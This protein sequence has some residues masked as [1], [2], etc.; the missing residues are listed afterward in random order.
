MIP[1]RCKITNHG[2]RQLELNVIY[3]L[4]G[5]RRH[6]HY[7]IDLYIFNPYQL[8]M[9][10]ER[11]GTNRFLQD[12][13][14]Y[15]RYT[16]ALIAF[17]KLI[18]PMCDISPITRI[19][20]C[21]KVPDMA[22]DIDERSILY[23]LR[24]L[25]NA[26]H[27]Q[28]RETRR[29]LNEMIA[30][31]SPA[32]DILERVTMLLSDN[33]AFLAAFRDLRSLFLD[34]RLSHKLR[35]GFYWTDEAVSLT[36]EKA[37]YRIYRQCLNR[38]DL[39]DVRSMLRPRLGQEQ[40]Y[41]LERGYRTII[42]PGDPAANEYFVY[43]EGELKKWAEACMFM[44]SEPAKT[45]ERFG[46]ILMGLSAGAA[47]TFAV[48]ATVMASRWFADY[49]VPWAILIIVAYMVKD[50]LK[51]ILR[52]AMIACLPRMVADQI[53]DLIDPASHT[54]VGL[55]RARVRFCYPKDLS[56]LIRRLRH[57]GGD[58]FA[59]FIPPEDVIHFHKDVYIDTHRFMKGHTRL[60][61]LA[62]IMRFKLDAWLANMDDPLN[63][64]C[65][66]TKEKVEMVNVQRVYHVNLV[67]SLAE[68]RSAPDPAYFRYRLVL[69]RD[70]IVRIEPLDPKVV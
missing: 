21:L 28:I 52:N 45:L 20:N 19:R 67:M 66:E 37:H 18:D 29:L 63:T 1:H 5:D 8:G 65:A 49:S 70:G 7:E 68:R 56:E 60:E 35:E 44:S 24:V 4:A 62:D 46:Q 9:T 59:D 32:A 31:Q 6:Q 54:K 12:M 15:T 38:E 17:R 30:G 61:G 11:Y 42:S 14:S 43:R 39:G 10:Q 55:S 69:T 50:R 57:F 2:K 40:A 41:R 13:R 34:P 23:E 33:D 26:Y 64:V 27:E 47:M 16:P 51:E 25:T 48:I 3:P 36:S 53:F 58:V 22:R